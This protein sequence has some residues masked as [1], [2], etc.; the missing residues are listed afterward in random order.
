MISERKP[1]MIQ[2][3]RNIV[4]N[5]DFKV[6]ADVEE[7]FEAYT[8]YIWDNKMIGTIYDC[9]CDDT[10]IHGE[11]GTDI[12]GIDAVVHHTL[13]RLFTLPDMKIKFISIIAN[14]ISDDEFEFIQ[15]THPEG[16]FT[17][18]SAYG[19]PTGAK[20]NYDN[21]MNMCECLVKKVDGKWKIV[22][23]WGLLGYKKLL[24]AGNSL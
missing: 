21:I 3:L 2:K 9:Y 22:E 24:S 18:P 17:G 11:N 13:E 16:T 12:V 10:I 8:Q 19:P 5:P 1:E 15:I 6:P 14:K 20:L 7:F 23:E 4:E